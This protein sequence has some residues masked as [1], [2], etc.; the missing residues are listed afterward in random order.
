M[1][2]WCE[3]KLLSS[4]CP[5]GMQI[6]ALDFCIL[7]RLVALLWPSLNKEVTMTFQ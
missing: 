4:F 3:W 7:L 1:S 5:K 2:C 6:F